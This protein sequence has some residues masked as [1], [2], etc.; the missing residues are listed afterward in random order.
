M[1]SVR[2]L[3]AL[4]ARIAFLEK[5]KRTALGSQMDWWMFEMIVVSGEER[6]W[7]SIEDKAAWYL[8]GRDAILSLL[9][10]CFC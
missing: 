3:V 2:Q 6:I 5:A 1:I 4:C 8:G 10:F 9:S 7:L